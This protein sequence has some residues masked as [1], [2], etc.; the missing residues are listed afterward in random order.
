MWVKM[1]RAVVAGRAPREVGQVVELPE[2][3]A[4][5]LIVA[6]CA[7]EHAAPPLPPTGIETAEDPLADVQRAV[8]RKKRG[9]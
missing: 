1:M 5:L 4:R 6:G 3:E 9:S 8:V 7:V 2:P